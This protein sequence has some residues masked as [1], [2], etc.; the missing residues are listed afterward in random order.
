V[1]GRRRDRDHGAQARELEARERHA[2]EIHDNLVQGLTAIHWALEAGAY[3]QAR[4]ATRTTLAQAQ[5]IIGDLLGDD[6]AAGAFAPG[7]LRRDAPAA[8]KP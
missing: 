3:D 7:S 8:H 1:I 6:P 5:A 4:E 2:L